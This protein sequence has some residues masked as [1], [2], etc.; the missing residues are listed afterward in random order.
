MNDEAKEKLLDCFAIETMKILIA[1]RDDNSRDAYR[2]ACDAYVIAQIM[3][4]RREEILIQRGLGKEALQKLNEK[5]E[6]DSIDNLFLTIRSRNCLRAEGINTIT[7]LQRCTENRLLRIPNF[8][9][10]SL[11]EIIEQMAALGYKLKDQA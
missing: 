11:E 3:L 2:L 10:K 7:Q 5:T 1:K 6:Q 9:R 8:G 4:D